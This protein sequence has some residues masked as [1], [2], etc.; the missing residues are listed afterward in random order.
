MGLFAL[1]IVVF[2][3]LAG[4]SLLWWGINRL[5]LPEPFKTVILVIFGLVCLYVV[6]HF[7][8]GAGSTIWK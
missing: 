7:V 2:L 3:V 5:T 6:Y 4:A 8:V 1:V